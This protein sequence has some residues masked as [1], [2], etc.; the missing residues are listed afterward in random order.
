MSASVTI[1]RVRTT[2]A[3]IGH[4]L[5][6]GHGMMNCALSCCNLTMH[7][8]HTRTWAERY[9]FD[10]GNTVLLMTSFTLSHTLQLS[11][12]TQNDR[13]TDRVTKRLVDT[14][15][16]HRDLLS[17]D[18]SG[19]VLRR[20]VYTRGIR[21][22]GSIECMSTSRHARHGEQRVA[23]PRSCLTSPDYQATSPRERPIADVT[24]S[25]DET[26]SS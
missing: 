21:P 14:A 2:M 18:T 16:I 13:S 4:P 20:S 17:A 8:F 1:D 11:S 12:I 19:S 15:S 23:K 25:H 24:T 26:G 9:R 7:P 3:W 22:M 5:I 6:H 10:I